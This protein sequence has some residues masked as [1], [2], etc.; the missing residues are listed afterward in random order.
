MSG[1]KRFPL[2]YYNR[3]SKI[4]LKHWINSLKKLQVI[5][6]LNPEK[7]ALFR[8]IIQ[9]PMKYKT[10]KFGIEFI[11]VD[12]FYPSSKTCSHCGSL[13]KD[14]RISERTYRCSCCGFTID[15]DKNASINLANYK[16]A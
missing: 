1:S 6:G 13:K 14:L 10:E 11:Q 15:R 12:R 4:I 16:L 3:Q 7:E 5:Q 9:T 2:K 8:S